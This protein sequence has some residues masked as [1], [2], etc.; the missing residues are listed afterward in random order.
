MRLKGNH[1]LRN[2][3]TGVS[4][5]ARRREDMAM[6]EMHTVEIADRQDRSR[7]ELSQTGQTVKDFH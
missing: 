5:R 2:S 4:D 1:R 6:A 3:A 7:G